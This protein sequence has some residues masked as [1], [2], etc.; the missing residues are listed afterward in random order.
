MRHRLWIRGLWLL[1]LWS[2][3]CLWAQSANPSLPAPQLR[4][5]SDGLVLTA[6]PSATLEDG[7][8]RRQLHT[9]LTTSFLFKVTAR[10]PSNKVR[11][12]AARVQIRY[13]LWDEVYHLTTLDI[14]GRV[15]RH[16]AASFDDLRR[17]WRE[18]RLKA[19]AGGP[20]PLQAG[21]RLRV[22]L[23][24]IPF[25]RAEESDTRR[26]FSESIERSGQ[27]NAENAG[28]VG[29]ERSETLGEVFNLL[30]ATSIQR[31]SMMDYRWQVPIAP[32]HR[33]TPP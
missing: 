7:D 24:V 4:I 5:A 30:M 23:E 11:K 22:D 33:E 1:F 6:L 18:L 8:I 19:L 15:N 25:S 2:G 9:G 14:A 28:K 26:W 21:R 27:G 29:E 3:G 13:E 12:G 17:F 31:R 10:D 20:A 16:R 32:P